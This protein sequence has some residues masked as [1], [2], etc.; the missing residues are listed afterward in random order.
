VSSTPFMP[1]WVSD[2]VGDT[3]DLDAK[4]IGAYMLLLMAMWGRDGT[5]PNDTEKLRRVARCGRDWP[6][7]WASIQH[8]FTVEGEAITQGRLRCELQKV[9]A[10]REVNAQSGARGGAAKALKAK[11]R[12]L[13]NANVSLQQPEPYPYIDTSNEVSKPR[14]RSPALLS[15][16]PPSVSDDRA[17]AFIA[18]RKALRRPLTAHAV[19]LLSKSLA[20]C[21]AMGISAD[22]AIDLAI[23]RGWQ[24]VKPDWAENALTP[25]PPKGGPGNGQSPRK[26]FRQEADAAR[27]DGLLAAAERWVHGGSPGG[28]EGDDEPA[29]DR[30]QDYLPQGS[31]RIAAPR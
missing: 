14:E 10:K 15:M 12:A 2:F 21:E 20:E 28:F 6:R 29:E 11:E 18:H 26:T 30:R 22:A 27:I 9:S 13:A 5:L 17:K 8:Y 31:L 19:T 23:E 3:L 16:F 24:T 7:V 4:E 1:L 25:N